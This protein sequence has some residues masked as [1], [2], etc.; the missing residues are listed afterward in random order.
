ME[1]AVF[2]IVA[3]LSFFVSAMF[4]IWQEKQKPWLS[5]VLKSAA[6]FMFCLLGVFAVFLNGNFAVGTTF[7]V[8]GLVASIFGDVFLAQLEFDTHSKTKVILSG[9][10]AFSVAQLFYILAM[11][12]TV[13]FQFFY[14][15][16]IFGFVITAAVIFSEKTLKLNYGKLKVMVGTYSFLL[17]TS[18]GQAIVLCVIN[19]FNLFSAL[20]LFCFLLFF[21]SDL[22]LSL[23]YFK[24]SKRWLYYPN[25]AT[26]YLA[27]ILIAF[28][29]MF[30]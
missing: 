9:M 29:I 4:V 8:I 17:A 2:Y 5:F 6:S 22:I 12:L 30:F 7:L 1:K 23:I 16:V 26:Y 19:G 24:E 18:L 13:N 15:A 3:A 14:F 20:L 11:G 25:L 27:Q 21:V 10:I 28:A